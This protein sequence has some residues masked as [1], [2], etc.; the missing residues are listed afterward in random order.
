VQLGADVTAPASFV[1]PAQAVPSNSF[2]RSVLA[3]L[4]AAQ[5]A[6]PPGTGAHDGSEFTVVF[7]RETNGP[8]AAKQGCT[9]KQASNKIQRMVMADFMAFSLK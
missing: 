8:H 1:Q 9:D 3:K 2:T 7:P 4:R 6:L 5:A